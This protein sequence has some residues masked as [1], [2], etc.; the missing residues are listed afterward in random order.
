MQHPRH[1]DVVDVRAVPGDEAGVLAPLHPLA[2]EA[3]AG[4]RLDVLVERGHEG[5]SPPARA[6]TVE[7]TAATMPW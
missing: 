6:V 4:R 5:T 3:V 2:D 7:R 1:D